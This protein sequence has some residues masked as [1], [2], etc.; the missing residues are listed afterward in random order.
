MCAPTS[1][2]ASVAI[3]KPCDSS[4]SMHRG[5]IPVGRR[6]PMTLPSA[7]TPVC[8]YEKMSCIVMTSRSIPTTSEIRVTFRLPS[9]M[10][11]AWITMS[12][13]AA[14]NVVE[15][16]NE[17]IR[18]EYPN[19]VD[20]VIH[21]EPVRRPDRLAQGR[22]ATAEHPGPTMCM[23]EHAAREPLLD[24]LRRQ[25]VAANAGDLPNLVGDAVVLRGLAA[26]FFARCIE[27][28]L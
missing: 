2:N 11:L 23:D 5:R 15:M 12:I 7:S 21:A 20:V 13:A 3:S 9:D 18:D 4:F 24:L 8:S 19:V 1:L 26:Q 10:R 28:L 27:G 25:D 22:V 6:R 14:G 16:A 17:A